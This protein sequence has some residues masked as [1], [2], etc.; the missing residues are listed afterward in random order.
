MTRRDLGAMPSG[1]ALGETPFK[2]DQVRRLL[3]PVGRMAAKYDFGAINIL[4]L[5]KD[6][7]KK[8]RQRILGSVG[9]VN[10]SRSVLMVGKNQTTG[11]RS[12][13]R[14]FHQF[15]MRS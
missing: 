8:P 11:R 12:L 13:A 7:T 3:G 2:E 15:R 4:H 10:I 9:L 5:I 14:T 1:N 6:S